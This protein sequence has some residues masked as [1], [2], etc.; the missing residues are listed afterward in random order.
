MKLKSKSYIVDSSQVQHRG[1]K[2]RAGVVGG[3]A[4]HQNRRGRVPIW[5]SGNPTI[6][7]G[8]GSFETVSTI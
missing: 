8:R 4:E 7:E 1:G 3:A 5:G 6:H 2:K